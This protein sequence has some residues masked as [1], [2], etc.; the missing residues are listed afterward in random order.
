MR[1]KNVLLG[2]QSGRIPALILALVLALSL[3]VFADGFSIVS[4]AVSAGRIKATGGAKVRSSASTSSDTLTS[5]AQNDTVS[6]KSQVQ[7]SDG[8]TWYEV[9]V[10]ADTLGYIRS[11]LVEITDGSTPPSSSEGSSPNQQP[12]GTGTTT[13]GNAQVSRVNPVSATVVGGGNN[14]VR[15]RS[16]AS[17]SS[18]IVTTVQNGLALTVVGQANGLDA[19]AKV[20]YQVNFTSN[21][22]EVSG[23]IRSDFVELSEE[24]TP[25]VEPGEDVDP[26]EETETPDPVQPEVSKDYETVYQDGSW[27]LVVTAT[28]QGYVIDDM[29]EQIKTNKDAYED[30]V[31]TVKSQKIWIVIL[32][33]LLVAAVG[34]VAFLVFKLKDM[35]D[36]AFF[37]QVERE[38]LRK[39]SLQGDRKVMQTVGG[40]KRV[41]NPGPRPGGSGTRPAAPGPRPAGTTQGQRPA[42]NPQGQ[43]PTGASQGQRPAGTS[44]G[45]RPAGNPQG[46]RPAGTSQDQRSTGTSQSKSTENPGQGQRPSGAPQAQSGQSKQQSNSTGSQGWKSKNFMAGEDDEFEFEFLNYDG[47]DEEE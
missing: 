45:Q 33:I 38:T 28:N 6:I 22:S 13:P 5:L 18:Q 32:V 36:S 19:D 37:N 40:D 3:A 16:D 8:Y 41:T 14:G 4:H 26:P 7:G 24:L 31:K 29:F 23:F 25:Y 21:N 42:G 10:D 20:W 34:A 12:S 11:D 39:R 1:K 2:S 27:Y 35:M 30:S 17:T 15:I 44:Q 9:Y 43:R 46:Q 47:E